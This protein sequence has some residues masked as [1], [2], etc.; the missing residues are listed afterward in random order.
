MSP[1]KKY[2][3][4]KDNTASGELKLVP[5]K[6]PMPS[7]MPSGWIPVFPFNKLN[8]S[9][10]SPFMMP[11]SSNIYNNPNNNAPV[12]S[13]N[14]SSNT[15]NYPSEENIDILYSYNKSNTTSSS[16]NTAPATPSNITPSSS[17]ASENISNVLRNYFNNLD[18]N[19]DLCRKCSDKRINKIYSKIIEKNPEIFSM[20]IDCYKIPHPIAK[21]LI[22]KI[23]KLS[24]QYCKKA[25]D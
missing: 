13:N 6:S 8:N 11:N 2:M 23:I 20:L 25:G 15:E 22:R 18:E 24:L 16:G 1:D 3:D 7:N 4:N 12:S 5:F 21:T 9:S 14:P 10:G 19:I 17:N